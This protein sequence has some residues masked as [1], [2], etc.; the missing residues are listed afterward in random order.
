[1]YLFFSDLSCEWLIDSGVAGQ[2]VMIYSD[3]YNIPCILNDNLNIYDGKYSSTFLHLI[4][5]NMITK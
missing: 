4:Y 5:V 3:H 2:L 1:M